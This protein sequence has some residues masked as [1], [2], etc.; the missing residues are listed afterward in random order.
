MVITITNSQDIS[1]FVLANPNLQGVL[2]GN[3]TGLQDPISM[4]PLSNLSLGDIAR[5]QFI[6]YEENSDYCEVFF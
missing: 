2:L 4:I 5:I 3:A 6:K 1:Q